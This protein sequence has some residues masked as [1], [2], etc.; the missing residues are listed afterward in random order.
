V[1][2]GN[3]TGRFNPNLP[4]GNNYQLVV[5][6]FCGIKNC[7]KY[8]YNMAITDNRVI[9]Q[10]AKIRVGIHGDGHLNTP[11]FTNLSKNRA[12]VNGMI[13]LI[14]D[15]GLGTQQQFHLWPS[16][17]YTWYR[18]TGENGTSGASADFKARYSTG[19][20]ELGLDA[21]YELVR[22]NEAALHIYIGGALDFEK[23]CKEKFT[24][25]ATAINSWKL[26][27]T[28]TDTSAL[29]FKASLG[30]LYEINYK[31]MLGLNYYSYHMAQR[32]DQLMRGKNSGVALRLAYFFNR[33]K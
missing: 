27:N 6:D 13:G 25:S 33:R 19:A 30:L 18:Y 5:T 8:T 32:K 15:F 10:R 20:F 11:K 17:N 31:W 21:S 23:T 9:V 2:S 28:T 1:N 7:N 4:V 24:G 26:A 29:N 3:F 12:T 14:A 16:L 22:K